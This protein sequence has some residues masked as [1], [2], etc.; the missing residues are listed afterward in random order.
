M[1][2]TKIIQRGFLT[3]VVFFLALTVPHISW[4]LES[5]EEQIKSLSAYTMG[6]IHDLNGDTEEAMKAY[7]RSAQYKASNAVRLRLGADYA[8]MGKLDEASRELE[9]LLKEDPQNVQGRY[10]LALIYTTRKQYD[11]AAKEYETILTSLSNADPQNIEIYGYLA[12]LYYSQKQYDKAIKQFET[13]V[14][15]NPT[16]NADIIYLLGSLYLE[17]KNRDKALELFTRTLKINPDHDE[18]LNSLAYLYAEDGVKLEEAL[19][20]ME[21]A[22][23]IDPTNGAYLDTL[24]WIYFKKGNNEKAIEYLKKADSYIKDPIVYE[25]LGDV[26]FKMGMKDDARKY[27]DMSIKLEPNQQQVTQKLQSL[28]SI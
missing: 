19:N 6:V 11:R 23:K 21:K 17:I 26:Y 7:E 22:V 1:E 12:Q 9:A 3:I 4:A 24:G 14:S 18:A 2:R 25:H 27:W 10:L 16:E 13:I 15:L 5:N 28:G 8:R 20:M